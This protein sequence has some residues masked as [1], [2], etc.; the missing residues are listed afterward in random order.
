MKAN[1]TRKRRKTQQ[2]MIKVEEKWTMN[3]GEKNENNYN[4]K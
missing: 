3:T 2:N 4:N 1:V